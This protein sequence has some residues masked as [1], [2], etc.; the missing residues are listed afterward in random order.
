M[1]LFVGLCLPG[2][3]LGGC[4]APDVR[5]S[6]E[7]SSATAIVTRARQMIDTQLMI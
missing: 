2:T 3:C 4:E 1:E 7:K 6:T 5:N